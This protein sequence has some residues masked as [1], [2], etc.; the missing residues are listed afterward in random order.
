M[1]AARWTFPVASR[2]DPKAYQIRNTTSGMCLDTLSPSTFDAANLVVQQSCA[3]VPTQ[4][5]E[6]RVHARNDR[7][8]E[9]QFRNEAT[10]DCLDVNRAAISDGAYLIHW[11][12]GG[13][14]NQIFRVDSST[15]D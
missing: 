5:W 14:P 11:E 9:G 7:V 13:N 10:G 3:D 8:T 12:C 4:I 1:P 15:L 6:L 2:V